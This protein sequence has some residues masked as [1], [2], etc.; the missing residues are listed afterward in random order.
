MP[1]TVQ[2][3]DSLRPPRVS[4]RAVAPALRAAALVRHFGPRTAD[5]RTALKMSFTRLRLP[6]NL[7]FSTFYELSNGGCYVAV[8]TAD[9][10]VAALTRP[11]TA[12]PMSADAGGIVAT[13]IALN[14]LTERHEKV[15]T[16]HYYWLFEFAH[17][18]PE[19]AAIGAAFLHYV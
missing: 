17:G 5:V 18:H 19:Q 11:G 16:E 3:S 1:R 12:D 13:L 9:P 15:W 6:C 7:A 14:S 8:V 2:P 10:P 4:A